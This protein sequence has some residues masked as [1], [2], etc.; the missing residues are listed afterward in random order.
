MIGDISTII[1]KEWKE[2]LLQRGSTRGGI[3]GILII[4]GLLGVFMPLQSG[5]EWLN[6]PLLV[7]IWSWLPIFLAINIVA[8]A[9]AGERERHTLETLLASRLSDRAILL[10]KIG[11]AVMYAW[12]IA[13]SGMLL[14]A[15]TIN[16][17]NPQNGLLFY[18]G[19]TFPA[20]VVLSLL[21]S[22]LVASLGLMVSLSAPTARAAYQRLSIIIIAIWLLPT[23]VLQFL[24]DALAAEI[25]G[26]LGTVNLGAVLGW[27][28]AILL[29]ADIVLI[30]VAMSRF[31][32]ARLILE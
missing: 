15:I 1:W 5:P 30:A 9:F 20:G 32:R 16:I 2:V 29:A 8:D 27:G 23:V 6:N 19:Y 11:A 26:V 24:P 12:G 25:F 22:T 31:R 4:L 7:L 14:G 28:A 10:G 13:V 3:F 21:A 17:A 18:Q